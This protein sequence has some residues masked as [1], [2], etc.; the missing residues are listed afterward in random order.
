MP[1]TVILV[2]VV[3]DPGENLDAQLPPPQWYR[4]PCLASSSP[5]GAGGLVPRISSTSFSTSCL[6]PP[7]R[8]ESTAP[9]SCSPLSVLLCSPDTADWKL[10]LFLC[11]PPPSLPTEKA[12]KRVFTRVG[13]RNLS[14]A[15]LIL[16]SCPASSLLRLGQDRRFA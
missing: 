1:D 12:M 11:L 14:F 7:S 10:V 3:R 8:S 6:P 5:P 16:P 4:T 15:C 2:V 9:A 13:G